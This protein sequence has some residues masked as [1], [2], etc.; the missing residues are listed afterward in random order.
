MKLS[1]ETEK[2]LKDLMAHSNLSK[3][4]IIEIAIKNINKGLKND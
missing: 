2:I 4:L 3:K 1:K